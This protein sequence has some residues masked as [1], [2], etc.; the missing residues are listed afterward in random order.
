MWS[1]V[2]TYGPLCLCAQVDTVQ[3]AAEAAI[4]AM[5]GDL[6]GPAAAAARRAAANGQAASHLGFN[7][8]GGASEHMAALRELVTLPLQAS[9]VIKSALSVCMVYKRPHKFSC[10]TCS[11]TSSEDWQGGFS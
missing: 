9:Q 6:E 2:M 7:S 5:G 3:A 4:H 10:G 8:L 1:W 11:H